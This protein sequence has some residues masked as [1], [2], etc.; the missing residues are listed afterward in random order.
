MSLDDKNHYLLLILQSTSTVNSLIIIRIGHGM[1]VS[2]IQ[3]KRSIRKVLVDQI[4][5]SE[6]GIKLGQIKPALN[7]DQGFFSVTQRG[8]KRNSCNCINEEILFGNRDSSCFCETSFI[9][10]LGAWTYYF[11][12][13]EHQSSVTIVKKQY[14]EKVILFLPYSGSNHKWHHKNSYSFFLRP[15]SG[16]VYHISHP[17]QYETKTI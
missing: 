13:S 6:P 12:H 16:N 3:F 14:N 7:C 10:T 17:V 9:T 5:H 4:R 11:C 8:I 1:Y 2:C 15:T